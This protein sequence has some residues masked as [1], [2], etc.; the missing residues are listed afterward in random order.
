MPEMSNSGSAITK[1]VSIQMETSERRGSRKW[2][3]WS[4]GKG[5][6][7]FDGGLAKAHIRSSIH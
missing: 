6:G 5:G 7:I 2:S 4:L 3:I 1:M